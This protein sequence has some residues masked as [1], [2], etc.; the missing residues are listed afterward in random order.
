MKVR[1]FPT[2]L[3]PTERHRVYDLVREA[4]VDISDWSNYRRPEH[5]SS[6]PKY[7]YNWAFEGTD[8]FDHCL[9][10]QQMQEDGVQITRLT[11]SCWT[12]THLSS[13]M[14][15]LTGK[16]RKILDLIVFRSE[17]GETLPSLREIGGHFGHAS[18]RAVADVLVALKHK[19]YLAD[20]TESSRGYC[21]T[22]RAFGIPVLGEIPAGPPI[23][24]M[25]AVESFLPINTWAF[26]IADRGEAFFLRVRG[27]SMIGRH[28][29]EGDLVLVER[30]VQPK[31][32]DIVAAII[33]NESTL[34]TLVSEG[35]RH[36][37][38]SENPQYPDLIPAWDLQIQGV[39]RSVIRLLPS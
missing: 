24:A 28:I 34:K 33:D 23:E 12:T 20:A 31:T 17:R 15:S 27:D 11:R 1:E 6:N 35:G 21:L 30:T 9:W 32:G 19:G 10:H 4:G 3:K 7:C 36:W 8:P 16:Q 39:G 38:R 14:R 2:D 18:S 37:L 25:E 5:P 29:A 13:G 22:E 26:G